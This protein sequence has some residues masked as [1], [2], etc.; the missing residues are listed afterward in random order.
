M[1]KKPNILLRFWLEL[2]RRKV[3]KVLAMYAGT[4]FIII[5]VESS[6]ADPLNLPR[7]V[8]TLLV[9]LVSAG[10]PVTAIL[11]WIFDMTPMGIMKTGSVEESGA[12]VIVVP[13][14]RRRLK[15]SDIVMAAMVIVIIILAWP[16]I[17]RKDAVERLADSGKKLSVAVMPFKNMTNDTSLNVWQDGIQQRFISSFSNS[18]ELQV[19]HKESIQTLL[20]NQGI[21]GLASL[22]PVVAGNVSEKLEAD[23]FIYG[24]IQKSGQEI[25]IDAQLI[26]TRTKEVIKSFE[27]N[28]PSG[29]NMIFPL[30][31]SLRNKVKDFL[32]IKKLI[33]ENPIFRHYPVLT[34]SPEAFRYLIYGNNAREKGDCA[35]GVT[36]GL[37]ALAADS[38][39]ADAA[40][41]VENSYA[42]DGKPDSSKQWLI[43]NYEKRYQMSYDCQLYAGWAYA[44][45]FE[46][47]EEQVRYLKQLLEIDDNEPGYHYLL[48]LTYR[49][50]KEYDK[51]IPEY[52][53]SMEISRKWGKEYIG[54]SNHIQLGWCLHKTG[55][56]K[57][58]KKVYKEFEHYLPTN[59]W[60]FFNRAI[61]SLA[62][63][64]TL[65]AN[66]DINKL[67]S[68]IKEQ[69][70]IS[71]AAVTR[72]VG[73]LYSEAGMPDRA[74]KYFRKALSMEP[75]NLDIINDF[76][77]FLIENNRNLEEI[78]ALMDKA[79]GLAQNKVDYYE[80]LN[81]KGW[82]YYKQGKN[83]EALE[84]IQKAWDEAPFKL[85]SIRS[86]LEEVKKAVAGQK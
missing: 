48:G 41:M 67:K 23:I 73:Q 69:W 33:K 50:M 44:F 86:H 22:S 36:W 4:A 18:G 60:L 61:L 57:K 28:G 62:E 10:F 81:T 68:A 77:S 15:G 53:K 43:R 85:Y 66:R 34:N 56:Y 32:L 25:G 38:T 2:K 13:P 49:L 74:E 46:S 20:N 11:A 82:G 16:K 59:P 19:R 55:Q 3:F 64:D 39:F 79:M 6:L 45:S 30:A 9:I 72:R 52:E 70:S 51:A 58:E 35:S 63:K 47:Y 5:Q 17:F 29:D 83:Q 7:W 40:F 78:P 31:D 84:I 65:A 8:G 42:C 27:V 21:T 37:K 80:Y 71:D 75:E 76:A 24:S 12:E 54:G 26:D 1:V 14:E